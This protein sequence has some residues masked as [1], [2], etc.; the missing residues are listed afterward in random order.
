[1]DM[2]H[3]RLN[4]EVTRVAGKLGEAVVDVAGP[5]ALLLNGLATL[6]WK[7]AKEIGWDP[8]DLC[9]AMKRTMREDRMEIERR[10]CE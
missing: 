8:E 5:S 1:M 2:D 4:V 6:I 7:L 3:A 10:N 9:D